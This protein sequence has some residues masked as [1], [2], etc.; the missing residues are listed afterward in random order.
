MTETPVKLSL[1]ILQASALRK[2]RYPA[3][4]TVMVI[5]GLLAPLWFGWIPFLRHYQFLPTMLISISSHAAL[6][7]ALALIWIQNDVS[8][9]GMNSI[10]RNEVEHEK[11][12][13]KPLV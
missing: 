5:L 8:E 9:T 13:S 6:L 7:Y 4:L 10:S 2:R 1:F 12:L 3:E 11:L